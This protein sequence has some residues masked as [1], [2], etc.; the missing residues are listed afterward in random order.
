M[1]HAQRGAGPG[2]LLPARS[3]TAVTVKSPPRPAQDRRNSWCCDGWAPGAAK[4]ACECSDSAPLR[5]TLA[6]LCGGVPAPLGI[7]YSTTL[8]VWLAVSRLDGSE[9]DNTGGSRLVLGLAGHAWAR[10]PGRRCSPCPSTYVQTVRACGL[11][12]EGDQG[13]PWRTCGSRAQVGQAGTSRRLELSRQQEQSGQ[14]EPHDWGVNVGVQRL[15]AEWVV[16][17]PP[18]PG[19]VPGLTGSHVLPR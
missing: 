10:R 9:V 15:H 3:A 16:D 5:P 12:L 19:A 2:G 14:R 18:T 13:P 8:C 1:E 11:D 6:W 7:I 4:L 17:A